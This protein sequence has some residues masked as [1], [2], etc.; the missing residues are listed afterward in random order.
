MRDRGYQRLIRYWINIATWLSLGVNTILGGSPYQTFSARNFDRLITGKSN[1]TALIDL[2][3]G[4]DHC[5]Q[6]WI[7]W[8]MRSHF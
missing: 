2:I 5:K 8:R 1:I 4:E 7:A 3:F 6:C